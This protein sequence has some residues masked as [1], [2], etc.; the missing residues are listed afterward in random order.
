MSH[1]AVAFVRRIEC[2]EL[3]DVVL[4]CV[5]LLDHGVNRH[6]I[7][8]EHSP[9]D[10][11]DIVRHRLLR[12]EV[13]DRREGDGLLGEGSR[14]MIGIGIGGESKAVRRRA[15][16]RIINLCVVERVV[17]IVPTPAENEPLLP[18]QIR[19]EDPFAD[20]SR[21]VEE[22]QSVNAARTSDGHRPRTGIEISR[23]ARRTGTPVCG[24]RG[25]NATS[26][27]APC[28]RS[29]RRPSPRTSLRPRRGDRRHRRGSLQRSRSR[30]RGGDARR[31]EMAQALVGP[32]GTWRSESRDLG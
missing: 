9:I 26:S 29:G 24:R 8:R 11:E 27:V 19:I 18:Y 14:R 15:V 2:D 3:T 22:A 5:G 7:V 10:L 6:R 30:D 31:S 28:P 21:H 16:P 23:W 13:A 17:E 4:G 1:Q 20:I 12:V 25:P 32:G